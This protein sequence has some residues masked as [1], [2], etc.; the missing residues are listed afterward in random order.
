MLF[1]FIFYSVV[2]EMASHEAIPKQLRKK[3]RMAVTTG[4]KGKCDFTYRCPEK[5]WEK[6]VHP[7][8]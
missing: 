3:V 4:R 8:Y 7:N 1:F 6:C 5:A 2:R